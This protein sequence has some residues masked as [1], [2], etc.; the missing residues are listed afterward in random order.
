MSDLREQ[1]FGSEEEQ[2]DTEQVAREEIRSLWRRQSEFVQSEYVNLDLK[3]W[4]ETQLEIYE[5]AP[6]P[7]EEMLFNA[8]I[9]KGLKMIDS[10]IRDIERRLEGI[11]NV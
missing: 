11:S 3:P 10:M 6:G 8:G 4:L 7:H 9:R 2:I 1:Y 5:T